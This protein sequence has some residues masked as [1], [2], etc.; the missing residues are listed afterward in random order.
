MRLFLYLIMAVTLVCCK[1]SEEKKK[2]VT[3][4]K[5]LNNIKK[6]DVPFELSDTTFANKTFTDT[7][8][9]AELTKPIPDSIFTKYKKNNT[10][11]IAPFGRFETDDINYILLVAN[12]GSEKNLIAIA[13]NEKNAYAASIELLKD[14]NTDGYNHSV[15][16]TREPT[17]S[18]SRRKINSENQL[19]YTMQ[20]FAYSGGN[21]FTTV[22]DD[23]NESTTNEKVFNPI[24]TLKR[25]NKLSGDYGRD[26]KNFISVRDGKTATS[27][28][29][30]IHFENNSDGCS[31]QLMGEIEMKT[32]TEGAYQKSGN[33]CGLDFI[34]TNN[35]V[36]IK[37]TGSMV[38]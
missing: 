2:A 12:N 16:I 10:V 31:G 1:K 6:L 20:G 15:N 38:R 28:L 26:S 17:F 33:P 23:S 34:F 14:K 25:N 4:T 30:F 5:I 18:I 7:L 19:I 24:D 13:I 29:F 27:Y 35:N 8:N 21:T 32:A 36:E 22:I 37:E 11:S 3:L 9:Y